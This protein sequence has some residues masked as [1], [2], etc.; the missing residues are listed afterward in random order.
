MRSR[1]LIL[2]YERVESIGSIDDMDK[3]IFDRWRVIGGYYI[4]NNLRNRWYLFVFLNKNEDI[5]L[6][7]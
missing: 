4:W 2:L 1:K 5:Y 3:C 6:F 7:Y